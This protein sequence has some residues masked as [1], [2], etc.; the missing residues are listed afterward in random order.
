MAL[1]NEPDSMEMIINGGDAELDKNVVEKITDPLTHLVRNAL[2]H[3]I[4][5]PSVRLA[6]GKPASGMV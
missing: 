5:G 3:G 4:E 2:D 1:E 6:A